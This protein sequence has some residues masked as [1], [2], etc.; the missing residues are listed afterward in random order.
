MRKRFHDPL[1]DGVFRRGSALLFG[2]CVA[3]LES[4]NGADH[5][6]SGG[7]PPG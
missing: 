4:G 3:R 2:A 5:N 6:R 1:V 7:V